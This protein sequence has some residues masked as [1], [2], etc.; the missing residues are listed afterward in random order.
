MASVTD[1]LYLSNNGLQAHQSRINT[2]SQ[3]IANVDTKG[4]SRQSVQLTP[5]SMETGLGVNAGDV[6]RSFNAMGS[7]ALLREESST[8][9]HTQLA[10]SLSKLEILTGTATGSLSDALQDV[11]TA[12]QDVAAAPTDLAARTVLLTKSA[13]L[14][15]Q[16]NTLAERY[17]A[18]TQSLAS[19]TVPVSGQSADVVA[20]INSLTQRLQ[21]LNK[22]I[23]KAEITGRSVPDLC[24]ERDRLVQQLA[25]KANVTVT[26]AYQ[27]K[28]GGQEL[29][30]ADGANRQDLDQSAPGTFS[31][32]GID[33]SAS[34]TGGALAALSSARATA[35]S[36]SGQL[37]LLASTVAS[38]LNAVFASGYNLNGAT[39]ASQGYTLFTGTAAA[40]LAVD[41]LLYDPA[42]PM[43]A[44]PKLLA[45]ATT[46]A[47]GDNRT[48]QAI[49]DWFRAPSVALGGQSVSA[50]WMQ[51]ETTLSVAVS[52][53]QQAAD[54]GQ[55]MVT[56]L[57]NQMTAVSGVN[58]DEEIMNL[59]SS[60]RA[61]EACARVMST[62]NKLLD[63]LMGLVN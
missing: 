6:T 19:D 30:S 47:N 27:I 33:V 21:A 52:E 57:D 31:I 1:L 3:N 46:A 42:N 20:E 50:F 62:A 25:E 10:K 7:A 63:T 36:L 18:Y 16:F 17:D 15:T 4:Y 29:V 56:M 48:A 37:D 40:D 43:S 49:C 26:P 11:E 8:S 44:K 41:P 5:G 24:D 54:M 60:Q 55:K 22:N 9:F 38:G 45:A 59:M 14:A 32:G 35:V 13:S 58:L 53:E 34:V 61:Y 23:T 2:A 12:W 28:Q 51:A 39:P